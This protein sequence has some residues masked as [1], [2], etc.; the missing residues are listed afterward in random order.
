MGAIAS[1]DGPPVLH[2]PIEPRL[3]LHGFPIASPVHPNQV[4]PRANY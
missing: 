3:T 1:V 2:V 4:S